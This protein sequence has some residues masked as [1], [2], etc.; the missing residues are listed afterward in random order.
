ML[1]SIH[2]LD[3]AGFRALP[4]FY[5]P[6]SWHLRLN[7]RLVTARLELAANPVFA[8]PTRS[9]NK[10]WLAVRTVRQFRMAR[11]HAELRIL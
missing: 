3:Y 11:F 1:R 2:S 9:R 4:Q 6:P 5:A 7:P 8:R 10:G